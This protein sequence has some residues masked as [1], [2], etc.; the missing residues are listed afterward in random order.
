VNIPPINE[1]ITNN[2]AAM[3]PQMRIPINTFPTNC[4]PLRLLGSLKKSDCDVMM[5]WIKKLKDEFLIHDT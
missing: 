3:T 2:N 1:R 5:V 4:H